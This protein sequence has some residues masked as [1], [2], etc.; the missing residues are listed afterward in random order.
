MLFTDYHTR[1]L[2]FSCLTGPRAPPARVQVMA[3]A[4][5]G[6]FPLIAMHALGTEPPLSCQLVS[7]HLQLALRA[8]CSLYFPAT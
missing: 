2:A 6:G 5:V 8:S 3:R 4:Q 1:V 7:P